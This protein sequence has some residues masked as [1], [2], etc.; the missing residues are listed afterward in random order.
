MGQVCSIRRL[1]LSVGQSPG[2]RNEPCWERCFTRRK[3]SPFTGAWSPEAWEIQMPW[4]YIGCWSF[5]SLDPGPWHR[6]S[7]MPITDF[8]V[9]PL[10]NLSACHA[11]YTA[12]HTHVTP[13]HSEWAYL[14]AWTMLHPGSVILQSPEFCP[15]HLY[16][17]VGQLW[18]L[19]LMINEPLNLISKYTKARGRSPQ[20]F[21]SG[22]STL[23]TVPA[24]RGGSSL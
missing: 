8:E 14:C 1:P 18:S 19:Y 9:S 10:D 2:R 15:G 13:N 22:R 6:C 24:G 7:V 5:F 23:I 4:L 11:R 3:K 17:W 21:H 20:S 12:I 16:S